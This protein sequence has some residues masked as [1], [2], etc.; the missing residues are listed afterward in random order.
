[1]LKS[2]L[3]SGMYFLRFRIMKNFSHFWLRSNFNE[4][5]IFRANEIT[6]N[7]EIINSEIPRPF[8][9]REIKG[10]LSFNLYFL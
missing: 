10:Y 1:M 3:E 2:R 7:I 5:I 4:F 8:M 9:Q 6:Y